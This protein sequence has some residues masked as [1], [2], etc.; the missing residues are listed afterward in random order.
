MMTKSQRRTA[1]RID[2]T[3]ARAI[4]G[5][6]FTNLV[7]WA[8]SSPKLA[9]PA[10]EGGRPIVAA[11]I[12]LSPANF[13]GY[14]VCGSRT[15]GCTAGC[16]AFAGH[17]GMGVVRDGTTITKTNACQVCR[18]RRTLMLFENQALF[19]ALLSEDI[20]KL[21]RD[22]AKVDGIPAFRPNGT[23]D[24]DWLG[25]PCPRNGRMFSSM[26]EAFP[27]VRF[28]DYTKV[29]KRMNDFLAGR[30]PANYTLIFSRA[31]TLASK[32]TAMAVLKAGGNVAAVFATKKGRALP[33]EWN[34]H[35]VLDADVHDFR[36]LDPRSAKGYVL[37]LR[38][39]GDAKG[40]TSGFVIA[41]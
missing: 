39:K 22:A 3:A 16:L 13:S 10:E 28:W 27:E 37:G 35:I 9:K 29:A 14:E 32:L 40:D 33:T 18:L 23:S 41:V 12:Y 15:K 7:T 11:L 8:Q 38:A 1:R 21:V 20:E 5:K 26:F 6:S 25:I 31:E 2:L 17:G 30:L 4:F 34:G 24:L 36:F 19:M